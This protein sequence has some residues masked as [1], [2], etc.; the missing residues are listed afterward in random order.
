[1]SVPGLDFLLDLRDYLQEHGVVHL[2]DVVL[3][4]ERP[5]LLGDSVEDEGLAKR[6]AVLANEI[7]QLRQLNVGENLREGFEFI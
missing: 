3:G 2:V 6:E 4:A 5:Q 1:M 7:D